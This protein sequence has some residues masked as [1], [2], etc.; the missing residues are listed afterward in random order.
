[1]NIDGMIRAR[2][3]T[4]RNSFALTIKVRFFQYYR[5]DNKVE[6]PYSPNAFVLNK[7]MAQRVPT[8]QKEESIL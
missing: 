3:V 7:S 1:M 2:N 8:A 5:G 6:N 4:S